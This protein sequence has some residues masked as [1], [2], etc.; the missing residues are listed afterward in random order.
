[1]KKFIIATTLAAGICAPANCQESWVKNWQWVS[2]A[3]DNSYFKI[4]D[5]CG[6]QK[7]GTV[8]II[9]TN[10]TFGELINYQSP[11]GSPPAG[12]ACPN[13]TLAFIDP[14]TTWANAPVTN[15][16]EQSVVEQLLIEHVQ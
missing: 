13:N 16:E 4:G 12:A 11:L 15:L 8:I 10:T 7:N 1:M 9:G 2:V 14:N 3:R 6:I 5:E